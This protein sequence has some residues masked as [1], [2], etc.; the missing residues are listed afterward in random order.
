MPFELV[1]MRH[2]GNGRS[3][4]EDDRD[5]ETGFD[6]FISRQRIHQRFA[7]GLQ[8]LAVQGA[9]TGERRIRLYPSMTNAYVADGLQFE[10]GL[11]SFIETLM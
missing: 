6:L 3:S 8:I 7:P 11:S 5:L 2:A 4:V 10:D 1:P 9:E